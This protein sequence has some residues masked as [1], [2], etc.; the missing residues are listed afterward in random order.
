M[1]AG[2][3]PH[4]TLQH[5]ASTILSCLISAAGTE[6]AAGQLAELGRLVA[7][8]AASEAAAEAGR[9]L[10]P[11]LPPPPGEAER[12]PPP[13]LP[14]PDA[15][16]GTSVVA[17]GRSARGREG[18]AGG[19]SPHF[20]ILS[21]CPAA[22]ST[23]AACRASLLLTA[24][25]RVSALYLDLST[26]KPG[27]GGPTNCMA[28]SLH[29]PPIPPC[30]TPPPLPSSPVQ[31]SP[32]GAAASALR[33]MG[34]DPSRCDA[35]TADVGQALGSALLL[36]SFSPARGLKAGPACGA[37]TAREVVSWLQGLER[38]AT[39]VWRKCGELAS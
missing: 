24:L 4:P 18:P 26:A 8:L 36:R 14:P 19:K 25:V 21:E 37:M 6:E 39:Q 27:G 15:D 30:P 5:L 12:L 28:L 29:L 38:R 35:A 9:L 2:C 23:S 34:L 16:A 7:D 20:S 3:N 13:L 33:T 31:A 17:G 32:L 11:P 10:L 22:N 1:R